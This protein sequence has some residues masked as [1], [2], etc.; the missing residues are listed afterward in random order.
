MVIERGRRAL[1]RPR[2]QRGRGAGARRMDPVPRR[3]L[4]GP[5]RSARRLLRRAGRRRRRRAGRR[6]GA[7]AGGRDARLALRLGAQLPVPAGAPEP[8][9]PPPRGGGQPARPPRGVRA[10][11]RLLRGRTRGR[12][13]G[14]QL[15]PSAGRLAARATARRGG[16]APLPRHVARAASPVARLRRRTR[17]ARSPLRRVHARA[18]GDSGVR[19]PAPARAR[20]RT[21]GARSGRRVFARGPRGQCGPPRARPLPGARCAAVGR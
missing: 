17:L 9:V 7:D 6:G 11:R 2:A 19:P 18:G 10:G 15:A 5:G 8:P 14:L 4:P 1:A 16:R 3:R 21:T 13:H 12:G 20:R